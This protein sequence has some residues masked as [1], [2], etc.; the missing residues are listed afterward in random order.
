M[1]GSF[2]QDSKGYYLNADNGSQAEIRFSDLEKWTTDNGLRWTAIGLDI[3]PDFNEFQALQ[4]HKWRL[5]W[6]SI[7]RYF[8]FN[9]VYRARDAYSALIREIRTHGYSVQ[10]YQ[11]LLLAGERKA[12][13]TVLERLFGIV[14]VRGDDEIFMLYTSFTPS[15]GSAPIWKLGPDAQGIAIGSTA[16]SGN[17]QFDAKFPAL[18]WDRFS[19]DLV[20][21][22]YFSPLVGVYNLEGCIRQGFLPRME[23][24]DWKRPVMIPAKEVYKAR[25]IRI[26]IATVLWISSNIPYF[27]LVIFLIIAWLLLRKGRRKKISV[28]P[29]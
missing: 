1:L 16:S 26:A 5:A 7:R 3:E 11:L 12:H 19:S 6:L 10:T 23:T 22:S 15:M 13:S 25:R 14:N 28:L 24:L 8:D 20:V 2:Y 27:V 29:V 4:N 17:P 9:R 21:A 18:N